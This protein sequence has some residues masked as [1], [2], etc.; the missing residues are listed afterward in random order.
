V[1]GHK[2]GLEG[3]KRREMIQL[4]SNTKKKKKKKKKKRSACPSES[5]NS[6]IRIPVLKFLFACCFDIYKK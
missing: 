6:V 2:G 5:I 4:Y 3:E 1:V